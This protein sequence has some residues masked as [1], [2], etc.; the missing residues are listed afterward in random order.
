METI[1]EHIVHIYRMGGEDAIG[2]GTDFDG[3]DEGVSDI[4]HMGQMNLLYETVKRR[5]FTERQMEKFWGKNA[6]RILK[7]M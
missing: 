7:E 6:I 4:T 1:A 5:G 2:I 3:F